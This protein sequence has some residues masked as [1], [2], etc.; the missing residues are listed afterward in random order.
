MIVTPN[1]RGTS[2]I[3]AMR[4]QMTVMAS[5]LFLMLGFQTVTLILDRV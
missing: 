1:D 3:Q 5:V 2:D 4:G